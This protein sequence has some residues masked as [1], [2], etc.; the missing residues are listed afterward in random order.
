M[1]VSVQK[2]DIWFAKLKTFVK[3]KFS[4]LMTFVEAKSQTF[5]V[6]ALKS[7]GPQ[8]PEKVVW[9]MLY[10]AGLNFKWKTETERSD[11]DRRNEIQK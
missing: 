5:W 4:K 9:P 3:D 10:L 1:I 6:D 11:K 8:F 2:E 7:R